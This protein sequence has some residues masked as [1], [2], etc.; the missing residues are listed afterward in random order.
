M[1]HFPKLLSALVLAIV[2]LPCSIAFA[3][4]SPKR[5]VTLGGSIT[6]IVYALGEGERLIARDTTSSFPEA[7]IA[8]PDVGYIRALSPEGVLSVGPD[9]ILADEGARPLETVDVLKSASVVYV[10]IP[11]VFS[12]EGTVDKIRI[13]GAA[14]GVQTAAEKLAQKVSADLARVAANISA[15]GG[16]N[17]RVLF[18]LSTN[19][20]RIVAGGQGTSVD[21]II[22][23]AGGTNVIESFEGYK[24]VTPEAIATAAPDVILMMAREGDHASSNDELWAMPALSQ[25]PAARQNAVVRINGLLL[26]GFGPRL[27]EAVETLHAAIYGEQ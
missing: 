5:V 10:E 9:L 1:K 4:T 8:L 21:A 3:D 2:A 27:P 18:I 19:G 15:E 12:A 25:T 24:P 7:A 22:Q 14:L 20:G 13:V 17:K 16:A 23:M 26:T 11:Q 6:E